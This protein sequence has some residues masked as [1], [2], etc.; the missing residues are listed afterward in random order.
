M[1]IFYF[2]STGNSLAVAKAIGGELISIPQVMSSPGNHYK[3]DAIGV[4]FPVYGLLPAKIVRD[5]LDKVKL[6]AEY[7]FAIGTYGNMPGGCM[8]KVQM[9]A[10]KNGY[11]FDYVNDIFM[12][13]NFLPVF[14]VGA[15]L[16]KMPQK[17]VDKN[18]AKIVEDI[19]L[20]KHR[21]A[22]A[23]IGGKILTVM[24]PL[25]SPNNKGAQKFIV[26]D[27]CN[28]CGTCAKVCPTGNV[29]VANK[30]V[31]SDHCA[32]CLGCLHHCPQN[33]LHLKNEKSGKRWRN[34]D[35]SLGEIITANNRS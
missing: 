16:E 4:V 30:V 27:S 17:K 25:M 22:S 8:R 35:V 33:A 28:Q 20:K 5:F 7:T 3:D 14:E 21:K 26:N 23:T 6:E 32:G 2:T 31:F 15:E 1:K 10:E 9:Q 34:P 24:G 12:L 13:D 19:K 11:K 18:L 29:T